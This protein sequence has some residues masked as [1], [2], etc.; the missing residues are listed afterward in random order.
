MLGGGLNSLIP[1]NNNQNNSPRPE[2]SFYPVNN[3]TNNSST[4]FNKQPVSS[5]PPEPYFDNRQTSPEVNSTPT[6]NP[7]PIP[8]PLPTSLEAPSPLPSPKAQA[9][10]RDQNLSYQPPS[11]EPE[12]KITETII[13][14]NIKAIGA[15]NFSAPIVITSS[16]LFKTFFS[17]DI[18]FFC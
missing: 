6:S 2:P 4:S 18:S 8:S 9:S 7:T 13:A 10:N 17:F 12:T 14:T 5:S 16:S 1:N 11:L 3:E 15:T